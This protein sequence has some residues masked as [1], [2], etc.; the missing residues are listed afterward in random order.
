M[1]VVTGGA[2][3]AAL[4]A[5]RR[6]WTHSESSVSLFFNVKRSIHQDRLGTGVGKTHKKTVFSQV[7]EAPAFELRGRP[8]ASAA[9]GHAGE[10]R[11]F[12]CPLTGST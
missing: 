3:A 4:A 7:E 1:L 2:G 10:R 5:A 6:A 11:Q 9:V 8:G 12:I